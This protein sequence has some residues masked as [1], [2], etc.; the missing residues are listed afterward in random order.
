MPFLAL[1]RTFSRKHSLCSCQLHSRGPQ[2]WRATSLRSC[3]A[4]ANPH[5]TE[6]GSSTK[7]GIFSQQGVFC[8]AMLAPELPAGL[9]RFC[10]ACTAG[11]PSVCPTLLPP[12][13]LHKN[14]PLINKH[15]IPQ[16]PSQILRSQTH[17]VTWLSSKGPNKMPQCSQGP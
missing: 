17:L 1:P 16:T 8:Q 2:L 6:L 13:S 3:P 14:Q 5:E 15:L 9:P 4:W 7:P 10:G 12:G 11:Q